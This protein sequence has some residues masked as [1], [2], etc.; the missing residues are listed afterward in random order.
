[1]KKLIV[2][3]AICTIAFQTQT[4]AETIDLD[5]PSEINLTEDEEIEEMIHAPLTAAGTEEGIERQRTG[6]TKDENGKRYLYSD[7]SPATDIVEIDG[8]WY[9]FDQNGYAQEG[10]VE[11]NGQSMYIFKDGVIATGIVDIGDDYYV[12][13]EQGFPINGWFTQ[14]GK[15]YYA[16]G[17]LVTDWFEVD[18]RKY[19]AA[20]DGQI[21]TGWIICGDKTYYQSETGIVSGP[22]V[23]EGKMRV[24]S[25]SGAITNGLFW[26]NDV[27]YL[28]DEEGF[29]IDGWYE[30]NGKKLYADNG[31]VRTG[32]TVI[33]GKEYY[34]DETGSMASGFCKINNK[35]VIFTNDGEL[36]AGDNVTMFD[37]APVSLSYSGNIYEGELPDFSK[38]ST[39]YTGF[40]FGDREVD[41]DITPDDTWFTPAYGTTKLNI[42]TNYGPASIEIQA[43]PVDHMEADYIDDLYD[44]EQPLMQDIRFYAVYEDGRRKQ[45][46]DF[47]C[48]LPESVKDGDEVK[49]VSEFGNGSLTFHTIQPDELYA[50]YSGYVHEGESTYKN[51]IKVW[52]SH[53][54]RKRFIEDFDYEDEV[55]FK[56][57]NLKIKADDKE[58]ICKVKC[59]AIDTIKPY[60][61][62]YAGETLE[63]K[64]L[65]VRYMDG[66]SKIIEPD[67]YEWTDEIISSVLDGTHIKKI[68]YLDHLYDVAVT[69][70]KIEFS[71]MNISY[72]QNYQFSTRT[73]LGIWTLT[74]YADTPSDQGPYV[75][76][77]ASGAPLVEGRTVAVS[78][79][80]MNRLGLVFGDKLEINGHIYIIEDHGGSAMYDK[81]WVDIFVNDPAREYDAAY[82]T[83][84]EVFLLR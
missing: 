26:L 17:K 74:A 37:Y 82:N 19:F 5:E 72:S 42:E 83:P 67:E 12:F 66:T 20:E 63:G 34:F 31:I 77:T 76:Q 59:S 6:W 45:V 56:D 54:G 75:G 62:I 47:T 43:I 33:D 68:K 78:A 58:V 10:W 73:S 70:R 81:N 14:D 16:N 44:G 24:F 53:E 9:M 22:Q 50:S 80:T 48:D 15:L 13:D 11:Y 57:T 28:C 65:I 32:W 60:G 64:Q 51:S 8:V 84:S 29:P 35:T 2:M 52:T 39:E 55:V 30:Y 7:G 46:D 79:A 27:L 40:K 69:A 38:L 1:M 71:P 61:A 41:L 4:F 49:L 3:L 18:G 25:E 36:I 21:T 23:I